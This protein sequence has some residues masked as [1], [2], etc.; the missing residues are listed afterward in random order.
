MAPSWAGTPPRPRSWSPASRPREESEDSGP[1]RPDEETRQ[2]RPSQEG[3][4]ERAGQDQSSTD[5][6]GPI[7]DFTAGELQETAPDPRGLGGQA[8]GGDGNPHREEEDAQRLGPGMAPERDC[9]QQKPERVQGADC[10]TPP[11]RPALG[12][13]VEAMNHPRHTGPKQQERRGQTE[14]RQDQKRGD[15]ERVRGIQ[16]RGELRR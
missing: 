11:A 16:N 13:V 7:V 14:P 4:Q 8:E 6:S 15:L 1:R 9:Q 2:R 3:K 5:R 12:G 10:E